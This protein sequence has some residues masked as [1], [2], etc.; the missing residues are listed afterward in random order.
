MASSGC[1]FI[2]V[3]STTIAYSL[4]AIATDLCRQFTYGSRD[5]DIQR[6][7]CSSRIISE[8]LP[9]IHTMEKFLKFSQL[10]N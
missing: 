8:T 10:C 7:P 4:A 6:M 5:H 3:L 2:K 9:G 1:H